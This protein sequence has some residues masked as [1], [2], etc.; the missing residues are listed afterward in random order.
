MYTY[1]HQGVPDVIDPTANN[2]Y[3]EVMK[4]FH[5]I[6]ITKPPGKQSEQMA[7]E[8]GMEIASQLPQIVQSEISADFDYR[9][10]FL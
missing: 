8:V 2:S 9:T 10:Y 5:E 4:G 7:N 6:E 3:T 1:I